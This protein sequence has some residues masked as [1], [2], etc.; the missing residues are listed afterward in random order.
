MP[1]GKLRR[2]P[3]I[4]EEFV[5]SLSALI[6][7]KVAEAVQA[8]TSDFFA[9][10]FGQSVAVAEPKPIRRRRRRRRGARK[11]VKEAVAVLGRKRGRKPG[12]KP[13]QKPVKLSKHGKRLGRPPKAVV[14]PMA[15]AK[16]E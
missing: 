7:V 3:A 10:K 12:R 11:L 14:A 1:R 4:F 2:V 9:T 16:T 15:E 5:S 8:A 13:G 6:K